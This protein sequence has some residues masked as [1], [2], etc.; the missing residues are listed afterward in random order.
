[1]THDKIGARMK[2]FYEQIAKTKLMRRNPVI[3]RID[4]KAFHTF[5][6]HL[7]KPFDTVLIMSMQDTMRYL[8][9][10]I[11]GCVLGYTQSDE[12]SLVLIDYKR[13][14]SEAWFDY[15]VQKMCS[16]AASMATYAFNRAFQKYARDW[17]DRYDRIPHP[18]K[19]QNDYLMSLHS[20]MDRGAMFDARCF[21][22]PKEEVT[23]MIYWRQIDA[24]KNSVQM[25]AR[26]HFPHRRLMN[27]NCDEMKEMLK[28][29]GV[30]WEALPVFQQRGSCCIKTFFTRDGA[31]RSMWIVDN[32]IPVFKDAD[33][34]YID[35]LIKVGEE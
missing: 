21:S 20:A 4:G 19:E 22:I 12:I 34:R 32:S 14:T 33:R 7:Q 17:E 16:V 28:R 3:I 5:T 8:C 10:N 29:K 25:L 27:K 15:E 18:T 6:K 2:A 23:N 30:H 13:L 1:M 31:R 24:M 11:Q 26:V 35:N 9:E